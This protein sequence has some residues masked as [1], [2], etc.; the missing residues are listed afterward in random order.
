LHHLL[1]FPLFAKGTELGR[2]VVDWQ[3]P[4]FMS[5]G[6][7]FAVGFSTGIRKAED[8]TPSNRSLDQRRLRRSNLLWR[9]DG[10]S[11]ADP[12]AAQLRAW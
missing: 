3:S 10:V 2:A 12:T 1:L 9:F 6:A 4:L 5:L 8:S 7:L 11:V